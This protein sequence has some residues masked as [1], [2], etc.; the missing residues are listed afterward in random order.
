MLLFL[1]QQI[2]RVKDKTLRHKVIDLISNVALYLDLRI[3]GVKG[4]TLF[5]SLTRI[6]ASVCVALQCLSLLLRH[7]ARDR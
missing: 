6:A 4:I 3:Y 7:V 2:Y 1:D 5:A